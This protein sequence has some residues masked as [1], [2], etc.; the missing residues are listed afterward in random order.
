M[1]EGWIPDHPTCFLPQLCW[2]ICSLPTLPNDYIRKFT[3]FPIRSAHE[4]VRNLA[5]SGTIP[6]YGL[7]FRSN[8]PRR[9]LFNE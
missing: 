9:D 4:N 8:A 5:D 7:D 6:V 1:G 3:Y 2:V